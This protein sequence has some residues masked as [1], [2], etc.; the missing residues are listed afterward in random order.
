MKLGS[1][2]DRKSALDLYLGTSK[3]IGQERARRQL[4]VLLSRQMELAQGRWPVAES[5]IVCGFTGTGKTYLVRMMAGL[6]GLPFADANA[7]QFTESGYAGDDLSQMFMPLLEAAARMKDGQSGAPARAVSSVLKRDDIAEVAGLAATGVVLLD[8]F[9]KWCHR[10]NHHTGRLDTAIQAELL[11][12]VEGSSVYISDNED[13][14]GIPFDTSKVLI[15]CA[16]AFVGLADAVRRRL[17]REKDAVM[18][19]GFWALIEQSDFV[20]YGLIPELAGRLGK[21]VF[22][23]PLRKEH[24]A[25]IISQPGGPIDELR[26]RFEA[27]GCRWDVPPVAITHL[28]DV[29]LHKEVG[30][31]GIDA[32]IWQAFGEALFHAQ[33]AEDPVAVRMQVNHNRAELVPT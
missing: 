29:A 27:I 16:G 6:C 22:L 30:A 5:A 2:V 26:Q 1:E 31:R 12:I 21:M 18:D 9:D 28:A 15:L 17:D 14:I 23:R 24:L 11:K 32:V 19:E 3:V 13:E 33:V 8:E 4:A 7:T 20:R 10:Y 25:E